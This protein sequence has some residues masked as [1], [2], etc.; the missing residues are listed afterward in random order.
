[1]RGGTTYSIDISAMSAIYLGQISS[2]F[3]LTASDNTLLGQVAATGLYLSE[4][5][6]AGT[7]QQLNLVA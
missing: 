3:D 5:G 2:P 4:D 6:Q 7:V 1:M